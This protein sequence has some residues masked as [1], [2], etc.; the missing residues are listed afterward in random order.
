MHKY[1]LR[2]ADFA[3]QPRR[4]RFTAH[5]TTWLSRDRDAVP[6]DATLRCNQ[7]TEGGEKLS[8]LPSREAKILPRLFVGQG[9]EDGIGS[10][11]QERFTS[12]TL[13]VAEALKKLCPQEAPQAEVSA[14]LPPLE[15]PLNSPI[16]AGCSPP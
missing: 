6:S 9:M 15:T 11:E 7:S 16:P 4:D 2:S 1:C 5:R 10:R 8:A 14:P 12:V 3:V 13:R